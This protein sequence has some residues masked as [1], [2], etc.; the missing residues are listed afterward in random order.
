MKRMFGMI[1]KMT[2]RILRANLF[3]AASAD[4]KSRLSGLL[5]LDSENKNPGEEDVDACFARINQYNDRT[6]EHKCLVALASVI[7]QQSTNLEASLKAV[8]SLPMSFDCKFNL[9]ELVSINHCDR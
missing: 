3:R 4:Q 9:R 2:S 5:Q 8:D 1:F 6:L 7:G